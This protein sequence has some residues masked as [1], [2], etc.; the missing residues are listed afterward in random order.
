MTNSNKRKYLMKKHKFTYANGT[1][2]GY[3]DNYRLAARNIPK[4]IIPTMEIGLLVKIDHKNKETWWDGREFIKEL[5]R[6]PT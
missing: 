3:G 1:A 4:I 2:V 5:R 6:E